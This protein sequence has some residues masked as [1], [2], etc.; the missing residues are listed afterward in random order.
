MRQFINLIRYLA[1]YSIIFLKKSSEIL[2]IRLVKR[3]AFNHPIFRFYQNIIFLID[4]I[5]S[6]AMLVYSIYNH[7]NFCFLT[8]LWRRSLSYRNQS[9]D[10]QSK[11]MDWFLYD[12]NLR[13]K[14]VKYDNTDLYQWLITSD[15]FV[16]IHLIIYK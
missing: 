1:L 4:K 10:L 11:W 3:C 12:R 16:N 13:H 6:S 9:I 7:I 8:P 2:L 15:V 14:R 5:F